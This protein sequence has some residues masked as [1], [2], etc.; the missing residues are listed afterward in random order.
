M[1]LDP[2]KS[3]SVSQTDASRLGVGTSPHRAEAAGGETPADR[4]GPA[5]DRVQLSAASRTLLEQTDAA[6]RVP[7]GTIDPERLRQVL[8]RLSGE[9]YQGAEVRDAVAA[10]VRRDLGLTT[11]E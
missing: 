2:L 3:P 8:R 9:F 1:S 11:T 7:Q 6:D 10:G 5:A 4:Q